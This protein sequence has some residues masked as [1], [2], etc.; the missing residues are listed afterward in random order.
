MKKLVLSFIAIMVLFTLVLTACKDDDKPTPVT[1]T[2][3]NEG[4][5][6]DTRD[7][8]T[9]KTIKIGNQ[10]WMAENLRYA[11][12]LTSGSST[13]ITPECTENCPDPIVKYNK[14][15]AQVACPSGWHLAS[16]VDWRLL[17]H[18]LGM[19]DIDT[20][21]ILDNTRGVADAIGTKLHEGGSSK[22]NIVILNNDLTT[23]WTSS[24]TTNGYYVRTF[25]P[26]NKNIVYRNISN[27]T[28]YS[29]IRC[30]QD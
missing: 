9:Y 22:M 3:S 5:V 14:A 25:D 12:A 21:K 24:I 19:S 29:C 28:G 30:M 8:K 13:V 26:T 16:D 4:T 7:N 17:E 20:A 15:G 18:N 27:S 11:G 6:K 2:P 1:S 10:T 23:F